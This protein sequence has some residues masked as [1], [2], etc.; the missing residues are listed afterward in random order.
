MAREYNIDLAQVKG[1]GGGG[2]ITKQDLESHMSSQAARTYATPTAGGAP[3]KVGAAS[4]A[5]AF[6]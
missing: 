1:T 5:D 3:G 6:G 2:R 4:S